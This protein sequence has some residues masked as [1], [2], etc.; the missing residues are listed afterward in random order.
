MMT[1]PPE[2]LIWCY[3]AWQSGYKEMRH[4]TFVE[5]LPDVEQWTGTKRRLVIIDDLMSET[6]DKVTQLFTK[7]SHHRNLSVMYIV[8]NLFGKNK[9]QRTISLN[10]HYLVVFKNPRDA[11]QITHL[12]KQMYPGKL[13]YVQEAF[14]DAT[15]MPHGYLL[16]DLRQ[17]SPDH[18]RL[19]TKL[20]PPKHPVVYLQK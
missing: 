10:S 1:P 4:V 17:E 18:L 14:K 20:F 19:R 9:E 8:Q 11:S 12:A 15:S 3:G 5:G 13:K 6:N 2:E 7:E 16:F